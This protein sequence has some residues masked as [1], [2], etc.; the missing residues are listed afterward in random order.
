MLYVT[1]H[2]RV[3]DRVITPITGFLHIRVKRLKNYLII[4]FCVR[5]CTCILICIKYQAAYNRVLNLSVTCPQ[6]NGRKKKKNV[7]VCTATAECLSR[8]PPAPL[9]LHLPPFGIRL[10]NNALKTSRVKYRFKE[11][12]WNTNRMYCIVRTDC[13][14]TADERERFRKPIAVFKKK[15]NRDSFGG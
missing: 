9:P 2:R 11:S 14:N 12:V 7:F 1:R 10:E 3:D 5:V 15:I 13:A 4:I 8:K 6:A